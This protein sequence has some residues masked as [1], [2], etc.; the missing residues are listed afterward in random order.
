MCA[1]AL[2]PLDI[3]QAETLPLFHREVRE[4]LSLTAL[5]AVLAQAEILVEGGNAS[6]ASAR[7]AFLGSAM[8]TIDVA[9]LEGRL[10]PH[11]EETARRLAMALA[12]DEA[13]NAAVVHHILEVARARLSPREALRAGELRI[14]GEGTRVL[15]DVE[16]EAEGR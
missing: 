5:A 16:L 11:D 3:T 4:R 13:A 8:V 15:V 10:R 9:T 6:G 7:G 2:V 1:L 14:R 12:D